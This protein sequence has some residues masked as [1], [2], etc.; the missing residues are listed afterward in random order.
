MYYAHISDAD[1]RD[2]HVGDKVNHEWE[3]DRIPRIEFV[4]ADGHELEA[5]IKMFQGTIPMPRTR[6]VRWYGDLART[7][8]YAMLTSDGFGV[9]R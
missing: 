2:Y 8:H 4:Q 5:V 9:V 6:V 7:I 3:D 1:W